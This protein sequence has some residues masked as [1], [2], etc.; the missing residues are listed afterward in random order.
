VSTIYSVSTRT[1]RAHAADWAH[2][3]QP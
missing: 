2:T 3:S 1:L